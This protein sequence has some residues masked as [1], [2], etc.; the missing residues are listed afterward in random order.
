MYVL[1]KLKGVSAVQTRSRLNR[2]CPPFEKK[3]FVLDFANTSRGYQSGVRT[4]L[5]D[6]A[7][8]RF[9]NADSR[10]YDLEHRSMRTLFLTLM[11]LKKPTS[12]LYKGNISSK[13]KQKLTFYFKRAKNRIEQ[14]RTYQTARD[15][16]HDAP[17]RPV[18]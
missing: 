10:I 6:Y 9:R 7:A 11:I 15:R 2:I 12:C 13:D 8:L 16:V 5:Y 1:K 18:L 14:V 3:T 4:I 17:F